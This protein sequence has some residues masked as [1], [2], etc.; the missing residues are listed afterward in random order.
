MIHEV[1][2]FVERFF[3]MKTFLR[4]MM[5]ALLLIFVAV[6]AMAEGFDGV[7]TGQMQVTPAVNLKLV[8]HITKTDD[9]QAQVS[10][11]SPDQ[12][13]YDIPVEVKKMT[14]DS[15]NLASPALNMT[16][17][18]IL[19]DGNIT[20]TFWQNGM[21]FPLR[22]NPETKPEEGQPDQSLRFPQSSKDLKIYKKKPTDI[23]FG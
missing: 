22:L 7:W 3:I 20:G 14:D 10:L 5:A 13:A 17:D 15:I 23:L 2:I 11:D 9:G 6:P 16:F 19:K 1:R 4:N 8:F 18:G 12:G 21:T